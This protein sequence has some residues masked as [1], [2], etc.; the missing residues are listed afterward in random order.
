M[1]IQQT[2]DFSDPL[3]YAIGVGAQVSGGKAS[4]SLKDNPGQVFVQDCA[5]DVGFTYNPVNTEFAAGMV[6][7]KLVSIIESFTQDFSASAGFTYNAAKAEFAAGVL[8]QLD[9]T[10]SGSTIGAKFTTSVDASWGNGA[11]A[12]TLLGN[13][14]IAAG[15]LNC[16]TPGNNGCWW[17]D[18]GNNGIAQTGTVKFKWTPN[19]TGIP[20]VIYDMI[21]LGQSGGAMLN[22]LLVLYR[23]D[24]TLRLYVNDSAGVAIH[25]N[26]SFG[27]IWNVVSG[28]EYEFELNIDCTTGAYRIFINGIL[29]GQIL[30]G[31]CTRNA[32]IG[33]KIVL[34]N[35]ETFTYPMVGI[36][37]D[38]IM[39]N[40]VQH[41]VGYAPGYVLPETRYAE[42]IA[43]CPAQAYTYLISSF[44][45]PTIT[46]TNAPHYIVNGYYWNG[47]AWAA[48]ADTYATAMTYAQWV[49]NIATFPGGQLGAAVTVK[50]VFMDTNTLSS[51]DNVAFNINENHYV[52]DTITLPEMEYTGLGTLISFD[53]F[54]VVEANAPR[55]T[56]QIGRSGNYL[57]WDGVAWS[58]SNNTYAQANPAA[59][60][61]ANVATLPVLGEI[62]GQF[63]LYTQDGLVQQSLDTL[64][65]TLTAQDY[66][67]TNPMV[68][69]NDEFLTDALV[70]F[71]ETSVKVGLDEIKY[72]VVVE[73]VDYYWDGLAWSVSAGTYAE[74]N[75][76]AEINTNAASLLTLSNT[77]GIKIFLHS[78]DGSTTPEISNL[79]VTYSYGGEIPDTIDQVTVSGHLMNSANL[80]VT[81]PFVVFLLADKVLYKTN[82]MLV[83]SIVTVTPNAQGFWEVDLVDTTNMAGDNY[84]VFDFGSNVVSIKQVPN[85]S[86]NVDFNDL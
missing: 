29:F 46:E 37:D 70:S 4:L 34:G 53:D 33:R 11:L 44:G 36:F 22:R 52:G 6:R 32:G 45:V 61:L 17:D 71:A 84:Y 30:G 60:F 35:D 69:C 57:Y 66:P 62:Y 72:I 55:Y 20:G 38:F 14:V 27:A 1:N 40:T 73:G 59:T 13:S 77:I 75:T 12:G 7:Q 39:F 41:T 26:V 3:D 10:P 48:S 49:A 67:V 19:F 15:K 25:S 23:S 56:L 18:I 68:E 83:R 5:S 24:G 63:R 51:I 74:S 9:V 86:A 21:S 64:I 80:P 28:T 58:V 47:A 81:T 76:V 16:N 85:T 43:T 54:V 79:D 65:A 82:V 2:Y 8:R 78:D 50:V 31:V 42:T